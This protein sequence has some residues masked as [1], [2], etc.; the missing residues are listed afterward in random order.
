[1]HQSTQIRVGELRAA[2]PVLRRVAEIKWLQRH[3]RVAPHLDT[4]YVKDAYVSG[5]SNGDVR[6]HARR[7]CSLTVD[8]LLVG[9]ARVRDR[10]AHDARP[11]TLRGEKHV[12]SR[13][14]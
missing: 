4:V 5:E 10:E 3:R 1:V 14:A 6:P 7:Q 13:A 8:L 9:A 2:D 12:I 11:S